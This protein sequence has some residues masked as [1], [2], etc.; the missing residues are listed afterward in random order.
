L[1]RR[2]AQKAIALVFAAADDADRSLAQQFKPMTFLARV[3]A[4]DDTLV[5][6]II[7][8]HPLKIVSGDPVFGQTKMQ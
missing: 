5:P 1:R 6:I 8:Y 3:S 2:P 7:I 4:A